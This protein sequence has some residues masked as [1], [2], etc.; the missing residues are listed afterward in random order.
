[1]SLS[2]K[3]SHEWKNIYF[4]LTQAANKCIEKVLV[5]ILKK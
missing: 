3:V 1:M 2:A 4:F 5:D